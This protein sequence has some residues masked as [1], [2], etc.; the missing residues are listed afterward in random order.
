M[1]IQLGKPGNG[2]LPSLY[3]HTASLIKKASCMTSKGVSP[4]LIRSGHP[5]RFTYYYTPLFVYC[6]LYY[7]LHSVLTVILIG[8]NI[9]LFSAAWGLL[10]VVTLLA[11]SIA[12]L[13]PHALAGLQS[14]LSLHHYIFLVA[15]TGFML[16]SEGYRG[17]YK[18]FAPRVI[19]RMKRLTRQGSPVDALLAPLYCMSLY[20]APRAQM[21]GGYVLIA[22][23]V[24]V[25]VA[26]RFMPQPWR[27]ILDAGVIMGLLSG[28]A[29]L[30][31]FAVQKRGSLRSE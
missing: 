7:L 29:S 28:I 3:I 24:L 15:W 10:G 11:M 17:F 4:P 27:G 2:A 9:R 1:Q 21:I 19:E 25:V 8:M 5:T 22:V 30:C 16:Y 14:S 12:R 23:I 20:R 6:Q 18:R 31:Y 13:W 26:F